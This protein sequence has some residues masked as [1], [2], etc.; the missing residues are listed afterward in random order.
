MWSEAVGC[1]HE[2]GGRLQLLYPVGQKN[3]FEIVSTNVFGQFYHIKKI[4]HL[5][6]HSFSK[7][8][9][10]TYSGGTTSSYQAGSKLFQKDGIFFKGIPTLK[11]LAILSFV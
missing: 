1:A 6:Y 10:I 4:R 3:C 7:P 5:E 9:H 2:W 8:N 11:V